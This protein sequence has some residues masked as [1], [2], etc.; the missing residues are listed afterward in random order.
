MIAFG[1]S[2]PRARFLPTASLAL[3]ACLSAG[4]T[5]GLDD[6]ARFS[7]SCPSGTSV[8]ALLAERCS[9][10]TCHGGGEG[11]LGA[12]LDL[13]SDGV[14]ATLVGKTAAT[15]AATLVV[16]ASP[17][18]SFLLQK[19]GTSPTCGSRMPLGG[20]PLSPGEIACLR[21]WIASAA[22]A[23]ASDAE[24]GADA[25]AVDAEAG[26][27]DAQSVDASARDAEVDA[28]ADAAD[29]ADASVDDALSDADD[30]D[31]SADVSGDVTEDDASADGASE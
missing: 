21:A 20:T 3:V 16:P 6:P 19:V 5:P 17:D 28:R 7:G 9:G 29:A 18:D 2:M 8:E 30:A 1:A 22:D 11:S 25:G 15:C 13:T 26:A 23:G 27:P 10:T 4:C 12:D 31:A 24:A 14:L